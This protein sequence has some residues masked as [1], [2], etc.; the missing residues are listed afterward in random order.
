MK[1]AV[2]GCSHGELDRIYDDILAYERES[3]SRV[4]V[5][6]LCGDFQ[7]IRNESDLN[8]HAV[9]AKYRRL[10]DF[11][12]YYSGE[13]VAP[14]LTLVIGGNHEAS[15]YLWE[16]Y[17]GGWLAP[18]IYYLGAAGCIE[19]GGV[20]VAAAS[21]IYK[22]HDYTRGHYERMPYT[23]SE[24]RSIYHTRQFEMTKLGLLDSPSVFLSHDWPLGIERYGDLSWLLHAKPFFRDEIER[25][26]LGSPP[27]WMLLQELKPRHWFSAHL[28]VQYAACVRHTSG[29]NTEVLAIDDSED[30]EP[31]SAPKYEQ[32]DFLALS[33]CTRRG[34]FLH[35]FNIESPED[36]LLSFRGAGPRPEVSLRFNKQWLAITHALQPYFTLAHKQKDIPGAAELRNAVTASLSA[37]EERVGSDNAATDPLD[38]RSVQQFELTAPPQSHGVRKDIA[39]MSWLTSISL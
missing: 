21:G 24:M 38:V 18:N 4:D 37:L 9:P 28:H 35:F 5:V 29:S 16:L 27:L 36:A 26:A 13:K 15:N 32:T 31:T 25:N 2:E 34:G 17:Y 10:G 19:V 20:P 33:K 3:G 14:I 30:D 22:E 1:I 12:R 23:D 7:A 6:L 8:C 39:R 11:H